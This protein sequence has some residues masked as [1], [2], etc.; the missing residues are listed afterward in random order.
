MSTRVESLRW[1]P[2]YDWWAML[3]CVM[4]A[5]LVG[6]W[7][8]AAGVLVVLLIHAFRPL[9]FT[10]SALLVVAGATFIYY[11]GGRLTQELSLLSLAIL[12]MLICY[13]L[14][15]R[16]QSLAVPSTGLGW[17]ILTYLVLSMANLGRGLVSGHGLKYLLLDALPVLAIGTSFMIA[18]A[19]DV[20]RDMRLVLVALTVIGYASAALGFHVFAIL[21]VRTAGV[22]FNSTPGLVA[23]LLVNLALRSKKLPTALIWLGL[24]LPLFVHQFLSFRR[25]L[26]LSGMAGLLTSLII[27][28]AVRGGRA[29]WSRAGLVIG[30]LLGMVALGAASLEVFYG[31]TD[32]L[33]ESV[34]RFSSI[35]GTELTMETRSNVARLME[36]AAVATY[37]QQS[38]WIGHGLGYTFVLSQLKKG[39]AGTSQWWLDE[40]YLLLWLKQGLIGVAVY[41]WILWTAFRLNTRHARQRQDAWESSWFATTAA[42]T[43]YLAVFSITDWPFSAVNP[44]FLMALFYGVSM[45][46][47]GDGFLRFRWFASRPLEGP[48]PRREL[49]G[50]LEPETTPGT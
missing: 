5:G 31:Q 7:F 27:F 33:Q 43:V 45:A 30:V 13:A 14:A 37:I 28:T 2:E 22:F 9:D 20:K 17:A 24:S 39:V 26:W 36:S 42:A 4:G 6:N 46:M 25:A 49:A 29:R 8:I 47:T 10:T 35:G 16:S 38:P 15:K 11:E 44:M 19:F 3:A 34:A 41:L 23:L 48:R 40:N 12:L 50:A 32:I 18:N 1:L 21:H